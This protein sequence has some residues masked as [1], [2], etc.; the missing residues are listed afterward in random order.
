MPDTVTNV[1]TL[2]LDDQEFDSTPTGQLFQGT[3]SDDTLDGVEVM[4]IFM[5]MSRHNKRFRWGR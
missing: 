5:D 4:I 1:E 3:S 2:R